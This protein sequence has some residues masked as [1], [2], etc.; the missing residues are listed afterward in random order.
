MGTSYGQQLSFTPQW[1]C[2]Q[3]FT[4]ER[5]GK[6]Y[7]TLQIGTQ[8]WMEQNL[9]VG[10][11][12]DGVQ[13]PANNGTIEKYCY[14]DSEANCAVYGGLY[15]WNEMMNYSTTAG[16]QGICMA[17]WHL[18]TD[19]EWTTLTTFLGGESLSGGKMKEVGYTHWT[20]PNTGATNSSGF[21]ALP[22]GTH[23]SASA[24]GDLGY[25]ANFWSSTENDGS[26]AWGRILF[27]DAPDL[28][29]GYNVKSYDWSVRCLKDN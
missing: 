11:R 19:A 17:G 15:Q 22:A 29:R 26:N 9:N 8:C 14:D 12:I 6:N 28:L 21:T 4:D 18:P 13:S 23:N 7:N 20:S 1:S 3:I 25:R 10:T 16:V 2:G 27:Y 5:D 24:F